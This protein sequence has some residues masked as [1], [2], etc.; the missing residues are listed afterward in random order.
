MSQRTAT[1][2]LRLSVLRSAHG[3]GS[4]GGLT[5]KVREL[6]LV[7]VVD[8][9]QDRSNREVQPL[10]ASARVQAAHEDAPAVVLVKR[11]VSGQLVLH[12]EAA[13]TGGKHFMFGSNYA[14]GYG[15]QFAQLV[16]HDGAVKVHDRHEAAR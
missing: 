3:D 14:V 13:D 11:M 12:L 6:T 9:T 5:S 16:G 8:K 4:N 7:G 2:G 15:P 1:V 10:A